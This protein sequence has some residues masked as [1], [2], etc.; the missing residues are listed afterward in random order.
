[1]DVDTRTFISFLFACGV[2]LIIRY[3][4]MPKFKILREDGGFVYDAFFVVLF[5]S[6]FIGS[7]RLAQHILGVD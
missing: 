2:I 5:V 7:V 3:F 4:I 1:M 6:V